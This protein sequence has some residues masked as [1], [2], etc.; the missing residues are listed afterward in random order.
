[1]RLRFEQQ[2]EQP[3][4]NVDELERRRREQRLRALRGFVGERLSGTLLASSDSQGNLILVL[5]LPQM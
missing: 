4:G 5:E 2:R 3:P 1:M